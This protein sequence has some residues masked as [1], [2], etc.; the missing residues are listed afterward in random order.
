[1]PTEGIVP[2]AP[3]VEAL[4]RDAEM[5]AGQYGISSPVIVVHPCKPLLRLFGKHRHS[6]TGHRSPGE[7]EGI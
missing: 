4:A 7:H 6:G 3:F 5:A 2:C 1:L